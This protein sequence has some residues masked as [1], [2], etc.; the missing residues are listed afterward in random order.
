MD[1]LAEGYGLIEGPVWDAQRGLLYS[2]VINGG[3]FCLDRQDKVSQVIAH[4][5]GI[6]GMALHAD[7][8]LIVGGRINSKL[9]AGL[10]VG[11]SYGYAEG[12]ERPDIGGL[13]LP[14]QAASTVSTAFQLPAKT[15]LRQP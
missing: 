12:S 9:R 6:G 3:V 1:K 15:R 5:R 4:R 2:D 10:R 13:T 14:L 7:G 11:G 8:G